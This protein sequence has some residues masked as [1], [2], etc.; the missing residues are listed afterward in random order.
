[1]RRLCATRICGRHPVPRFMQVHACI[2]TTRQA[3]LGGV[4]GHLHAPYA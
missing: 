4:Q 2:I 3:R 1:M